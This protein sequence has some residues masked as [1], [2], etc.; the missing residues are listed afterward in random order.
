MEKETLFKRKAAYLALL[1]LSLVLFGIAYTVYF[2]LTEGTEAAP[3]CLFKEMYSLY[4]PGCG[5]SR[6]LRAF[7]RLDF[8]SS[9]IYYP[10]ITVGFLTVLY[11]DIRTL[12]ALVKRDEG[13][14]KISRYLY[15]LSIPASMIL[16]FIL[17]NIL[18]LRLGYDP[19]GDIIF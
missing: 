10:P 5:G 8:V 4:C 2:N 15:F 3:Q 13:Y 1:N 16:F 11:F 17:R 7:L 6:A 14:F 18:L 12:V 19:L 9:F